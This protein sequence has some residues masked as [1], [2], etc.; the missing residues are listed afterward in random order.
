MSPLV[1]LLALRA[2]DPYAALGAAIP[3]DEWAA[4]QAYVADPTE[5]PP[6]FVAP[7]AT[8]LEA[9]RAAVGRY[10][11]ILGGL[12]Q[13]SAQ[14]YRREDGPATAEAFGAVK[15]VARLVLFAAHVRFAD[16]DRKGATTALLD[17]LTMARRVRGASTLAAYVGVACESMMMAG[18]ESHLDQIPLPECDRVRAAA[19]A[20]LA[21]RPELPFDASEAARRALGAPDL[22]ATKGADP[23]LAAL[24]KDAAQ[25]RLLRLHMRVEAYRWRWDKPPEALLDAAPAVEVDDPLTHLPFR[26]EPMGTT[27]RLLSDGFPELGPMGL[28]YRREPGRGDP[29][30]PPP[31]VPP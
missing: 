12:H 13:A 30:A 18:F 14:P 26:Y 28:K 27:Y 31:V 3:A 10:A 11:A 15:N 21:E 24:A 7:G 9:Q 2:T 8:P 5:T 16:G 1:A 23:L 6:R 22:W 29:D 25:L 4:V 19:D 20:A 17:G